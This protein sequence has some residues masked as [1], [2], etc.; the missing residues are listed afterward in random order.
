MVQLVRKKWCN[1]EGKND[2]IGEEGIVRLEN[3]ATGDEKKMWL[4]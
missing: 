3:G 1:R 4:W 2:T